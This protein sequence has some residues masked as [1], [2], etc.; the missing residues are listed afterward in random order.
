MRMVQ[1][2]N[3]TMMICGFGADNIGRK[4]FDLKITNSWPILSIN[5]QQPQ[6]FRN[7]DGVVSQIQNPFQHRDMGFGNPQTTKYEK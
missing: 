1:Q 3:G 7:W 2:L 6:F 5:T 4:V